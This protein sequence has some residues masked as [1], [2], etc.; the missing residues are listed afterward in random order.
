MGLKSWENRSRLGKV[1]MITV[2]KMS[3]GYRDQGCI[4]NLSKNK[5]HSARPLAD[6]NLHNVQKSLAQGRSWPSAFCLRHNINDLAICA[7]SDG[8][9]L[10]FTR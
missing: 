6:V 9:G 4:Y 1:L 3:E 2:V 7:L 5:R 10:I 8:S